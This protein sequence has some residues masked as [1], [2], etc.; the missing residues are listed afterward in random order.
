MTDKTLKVPIDDTS[1]AQ[2]KHFNVCKHSYHQS[3]LAVDDLVQ[4]IEKYRQRNYNEDMQYL[5]QNLG[6]IHL[7]FITILGMA[8]LAESLKTS[9]DQGLTP[10]DFE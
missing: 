3:I 8:R 6:G 1:R 9:Y 10:V 4:L 5:Q 2:G 7:V